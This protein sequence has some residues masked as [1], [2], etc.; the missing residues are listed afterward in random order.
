MQ[1]KNSSGLVFDFSDSGALRSIVVDPIRIGIRPPSPFSRSGANLY[2]RKRSSTLAY[3]PLL[4]PLSP[5]KFR[6]VD[7][8]FEASGSWEG[9]EYVCD[10]R[11]AG[12]Q[13]AWQWRV[14]VQS[15]LD[16]P[17]Q[18]DVIFV[19][20][21][22][23]QANNA[24]LVNES[25][26]SQY[27]ERRVFEHPR[28]GAV[29]A[30]RQ[31]MKGAG[32]QP[33]L[34]LA[35]AGRASTASTDGLQFFGRSF[36]ATGEPEALLSAALGGE[37]SGEASIVALQ[38]AP[39]DLAKGRSHTSA[40][41]AAYEADHPAASSEQDLVRLAGV[42]GSFG[43]ELPP[44]AAGIA[45]ARDRFQTARLL[46]AED[47]SPVELADLFGSDQR[48][49][50]RAAESGALLSFFT[51]NAEHVVLRAKELLVD[52]PHGHIMQ[53]KQGT[54][55][56][57]S[58][59]STT[60]FACGVFN[61]HI[62][63]GNTNF[64]TLLSVCTNPATPAFEGQRVL[65]QLDDGEYLLGVPSA[66]VMGLNHCTWLYK[67][68]AYCFQARTWTDVAEPRVHF[69]F[70]VLQG[71]P[72]GVAI[73]HQF[74][75]SNGWSISAG[76][77]GEYTASPRAGSMLTEQF[78]HA[79][80]RM[81]VNSAERE[82][83][84]HT[85]VV[86]GD[87]A[88]ALFVIEQAHTTS[89]CMSFVGEVTGPSATARIQDADTAW[90]SA[91]EASIQAWRE[92]SRELTLRGPEQIA[93]IREVLPWYGLNALI[94]FLTPYG[95]EQFSGAAWGTRDVCQGP[96]ELLLS[97]EKYAEVKQVLCVLFSHQNADG[98]WPQWWMFDHFK[99]V[100]ADSAHGDVIYWCILAL[101][102]YIK[103]S[104]DFAVLEEQ[105]P[106]FQQQKNM[107][108]VAHVDRI[109]DMIVKSFVPGTALV[110]FGGGD[111]NDS[112]QPVSKEL[113]RRLISSWTVQMSYQALSEYRDVCARA[114]DTERAQRLGELSERIVA[115]F[116]RH[117]VRDGI[118]AGYGLVGAE[119]SIDVLLHPSDTTTGVK[120][121]LLPMNRG[122][123]SG[124]FDKEQ[125]ERHLAIIH[126]HL[127]GPDG[128]RL[129]DRP[130]R[131]HGGPQSIFQ[132]AESSTYF[133]REIGLMYVH[134]H[135]RFAES[136]ARL[137]KPAAFLHALRQAIPVDYQQVVP[138]GEL[139]Q[140]N[141]YYSSSDVMFKS[142]Y[143]ADALYT[144]VIAGKTPLKGGW[145]VYSSGPGI[146]VALIVSRLLGLRVEL[147][148]L[149]IDP[150]LAP[151]LDG[152]QA[153]LRF[154]GRPV[155]FSYR[156][157]GQGFGPQT[158]SVNAKPLLFKLEENRYRDG[159]AVVPITRFMSMLD[160]QDNSVEIEV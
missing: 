116:Q 141:C 76:A 138:Q 69:D 108:L 26:V 139:R 41:V 101:C 56:D 115:D 68:G 135:L 72:V 143:D 155:T 113:A 38:E 46:Q 7:G 3:T 156:V 58:M 37:L 134:E 35:C 110:Q 44:A 33:W 5:S 39:F 74:D 67:R 103:A 22:G 102:S 24:G 19:Q 119:G 29:V 153:S 128:A 107:A 2:L 129:M 140:A 87:D 118:V 83:V 122:V 82:H 136:Q 20:D 28:H 142:R 158:I 137:G 144:D 109:V 130:L 133:G 16:E 21:V 125:A 104:G 9:L 60:A 148:N 88:A 15:K 91:R 132:R 121:S 100:R 40:F 95:L 14:R 32:G 152:L 36:R 160:A 147:G 146:Y 124:V 157:S 106:F 43:A 59:L 123:I 92:L 18:L 50:E 1:I 126:E 75:A 117:L 90:R 42:L 12:S 65:V 127:T 151:E 81:L 89:F 63:Q 96:I 80:F 79:R 27:L 66:F 70:K 34:L 154:R 98:S 11:L 64:S 85:D 86:D 120:Y 51:G 31:N 77:A 61:S 48:H 93:A 10:L 71:G 62:T 159:G 52:R 99:A 8:G 4:G 97:Q 112:L 145:R 131:Y 30:C 6:A 23:L 94:H 114:G 84:S 73:T 49:V 17:V 45:P 78:P 55:P 111:W 47:L 105:L 149:I 13:L 53:A 25:Y 57:E 150:V 54:L